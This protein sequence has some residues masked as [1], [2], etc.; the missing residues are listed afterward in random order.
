MAR[1]EGVIVSSVTPFTKAGGR[2]DAAWFPEHSS[3]LRRGGVKGLAVLG[4][5]GEGP[6]MALAERKQM[7][8]L[9][10]LFSGE[11]SVVVG[12]GSASVPEAVAIGAYAAEK[13][14]DAIL[15]M[16]PHAFEDGGSTSLLTFVSAVLQG[17]PGGCQALLY[18]DPRQ[19]GGD[20]T[21][22]AIEVLLGRFPGRILGI[23]DAGG[24]VEHL[25]GLVA[26]YPQ[27]SIYAGRDA[28]MLAG[29]Q[30]GAAGAFSNMAN[31]VPSGIVDLLEACRQGEDVTERDLL[32]TQM[33]EVLAGYGFVSAIKGLIPLLAD[34]G[35]T[36][37]RP[38]HA[39]PSL[40]ELKRLEDR[41]VEAFGLPDVFHS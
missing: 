17:L 38:P 20:L 6:A 19:P 39:L 34:P 23:K 7:V 28:M 13:G 22:S 40:W 12:T 14:A 3:H 4:S 2:V 41:M 11:M 35:M 29:L 1:L 9:A 21:D 26:R 37:P 30:A 31:V 24:D 25:A 32:V 10:T 15:V 36:Y 27:L 33:Q 18:H 16:P 8:D 5:M